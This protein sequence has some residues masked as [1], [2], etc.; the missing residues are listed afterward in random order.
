MQVSWIAT[1]KLHTTHIVGMHIGEVCIDMDGDYSLYE[2]KSDSETK[3]PPKCPQC[4]VEYK[5]TENRSVTPIRRH[6][7]GLQK[8]NQV[9]ADSMIRTMKN[10]KEVNTKVVL[11]SDSRQS[12]AKLSAGIE[13]DHYR[14]VLRWTILNALNGSDETISFLKKS[15]AAFT[16]S[17]TYSTP[18]TV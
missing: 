12:A 16:L 18:R 15:R 5:L 7:T 17:K 13:L 14:D 1:S 4:E 2:Q 11:F 10:A 3:F 9:L 6:G 8:V